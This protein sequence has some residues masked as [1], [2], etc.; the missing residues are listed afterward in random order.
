MLTYTRS[1]LLLTVFVLLLTGCGDTPTG[2]DPDEQADD[3]SAYLRTLSYDADALLN[4]QPAGPTDEAEQAG[5]STALP[6]QRDGLNEIQC[7]RTES[8]LLKNFDEVAIL[9]PTTGVV[10]PGALVQGNGSL[11][12]GAP[13]PLA[14][15]RAPITVR[16]NLPGM[17][18]NGTR[19]IDV[20]TNSSVGAS[21]DDAL[22]WWNANAYQDGYTNP[23]QSSFQLTQS[24]SSEQAALQVGLNAVW[25]TGDASSQFSYRSTDQKSVVLAVFKQAFYDVTLDTP[26]APES[27]F[28]EDVTVEDVQRVIDNDT[29]PA[30][31]A[32]VTYGRLIMARMETTARLE[33]AELEAA[34]RNMFTA[35][36]VSAE[37]EADYQKVN[38]NMT[39]QVVT[40]GGNAA[41]ATEALDT[42][43]PQAL[44]QGVQRVIQGE[45]AVYS[46]QNPGV[47]IAYQVRY[48]RDHRLAKM[49][50]TTEFATTECTTRK[51]SS[52]VTVTFHDFKVIDD[53]DGFGGGGGEFH[54]YSTAFIGSDPGRSQQ[55]TYRR[56]NSFEDDTTIPI[57][58]S[59]SFDI[60]NRSGA[61]F[62]VYFRSYETDTD[63]FGNSTRDD[64][65]GDARS[66]FNYVYNETGWNGY[67]PR[68]KRRTMTHGSG[69]CRASFS[70]S[71][72]IN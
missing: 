51:V 29:P 43:S 19:T 71:V 68:S 47:P 14:F 1:S 28:G 63:V 49:G 40:L 2:I 10:W 50:Y 27:V 15:S 53:C 11:L 30:Y 3:I 70:Y 59:A 48:L 4:V 44:I 38:R 7:T 12:D 31:V 13:E 39:V 37:V 24:F 26:S 69:N 18:R 6:P 23:A 52:R 33:R 67:N 20:P 55:L 61:R 64:R 58:A 36:E 60:D 72:S 56:N 16:V 42:S 54:L 5:P 8:S 34:A 45:N 66:T 41:V 9:R 57:D 65:M 21:I 25:A 17:G 32:S 62:G 22:E 35:T 46:R